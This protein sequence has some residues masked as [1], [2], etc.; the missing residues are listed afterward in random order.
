MAENMNEEVFETETD[1]NIVDEREEMEN[2]LEELKES[3]DLREQQTQ[4]LLENGIK[5]GVGF[6]AGVAV[7]KT[8]EKVKNLKK[9]PEDAAPK[10]KKEHFWNKI[11]FQSPIKIDKKESVPAENNNK[12]EGEPNS[13]S[14][15]EKK[16]EK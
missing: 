14:K 2:E 12:N 11:H 6:A 7:G 10:E 1:E 9:H 16:A 4:T 15:G 13:N 3:E 8:I 5:L